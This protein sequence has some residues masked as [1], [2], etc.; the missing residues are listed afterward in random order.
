MKQQSDNDIITPTTSTQM[1]QQERAK[2]RQMPLRN[3]EIEIITARRQRKECERTA[4]KNYDDFL[5]KYI[6][7]LSF[8]L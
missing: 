1:N 2:D 6:H 8:S 3:D 7:F 5:Y 4:L